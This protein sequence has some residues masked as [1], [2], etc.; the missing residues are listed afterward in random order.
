M[1][2][3][4]MVLYLDGL[5]QSYGTYATEKYKGT[6]M[7]PTKSAVIGMLSCALGYSREERD[8]IAELS[9]QLKM[10]VRRDRISRTVVDYQVVAG[11]HKAVEDM[12]QIKKKASK[13]NVNSSELKRGSN[14]V[15]D[16]AYL[17]DSAFTVVLEGDYDVLR[18]CEDAI[19][20]PKWVYSLGRYNCMP[21]VPI[22]GT[23]KDGQKWDRVIYKEF[24][25]L[26]DALSSVPLCVNS[27]KMESYLTQIETT[28]N[29][30]VA[31]D[32]K[33]IPD[34]FKRDTLVG[35]YSY[36]NRYVYLKFVPAPMK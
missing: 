31:H 26:E 22:F 9:N 27:T 23:I 36:G 19:K 15:L 33:V 14:K 28:E 12:I 7:F 8:K 30:C 1:S 25:S 13:K 29:S 32:L 18:L 6:E 16:K 35:T 34:E 10:G 21:S 11:K 24:D 17:S 4:Y 20:N 2:K 5:F 3:A